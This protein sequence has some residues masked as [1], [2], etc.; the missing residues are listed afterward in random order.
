MRAPGD[1]LRRFAFP[2]AL[3]GLNVLLFAAFY[4]K[5]GDLIVDTSREATLP[6]RILLG[7]VPYRDFNYEYGPLALYY[8][9]FFYRLAGVNLLALNLAGL[10]VS[11]AVSVMVYALSRVFLNRPLSLF[12][13]AYFILNFAFQNT[14]GFNIYTYI[15][16]YT[17]A[18]SLGVLLLL[19]VFCAGHRWLQTG[20]AAWGLG[21][22]LGYGL[23]CLTKVEFI[24]AGAV[25][26][27]PL[28]AALL[29]KAWREGRLGWRLAGRWLAAFALP[30]LALLLPVGCYFA[31]RLDIPAYLRTEISG[32]LSF[33]LPFVRSRMGLLELTQN[34]KTFVPVL[35]AYFG[36]ALVFHA[37]DR[38]TARTA[39]RDDS[40]KRP[41]F[42]EAGGLLLAGML[43]WLAEE[44]VGGPNV[45][46]GM[47]V[48]LPLI[49]GGALVVAW[50][51]WRQRSLPP[52]AL[53]VAC[54]SASACVLLVRVV[55]NARP[56]GYG[57]FL[58]VPGLLL[59]LAGVFAFLPALFRRRDAGNRIYRWGFVVFLTAMTA[60]HFKYSLDLYREKN[61]PVTT[62]RGTLWLPPD[63]QQA[64]AGL[65][66]FFRDKPVGHLL[67]LPEGAMLNFL[68]D[69]PPVT[70]S[71]AFVPPLLDTPA[72]E[73]RVIRE[74]R[75]KPIDYIL[76][77]SR[78]TDEFGFSVF[79]FDYAWRL[80]RAFDADYAAVAQFGPPPFNPQRYFG[81]LAMERT[82]RRPA[83]EMAAPPPAGL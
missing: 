62:A 18:A 57:V 40:G 23:L 9:A 42:A 30:A 78:W 52:R 79:G 31:R 56:V 11:A 6:W 41:L 39:A 46:A 32:M 67:A 49:G 64:L 7:D 73:D 66:E 44:W 80:K 61:C 29:L 81:I 63:Q 50:R 8:V 75:E 21:M 76:I 3:V 33:D 36:L 54:L 59:T 17:F 65:L 38:W 14:G 35:A 47:A 10:A 82:D 24:L 15:L 2:L 5:F 27:L 12:A 51:G 43:A 34:L 20:R 13:G 48:W 55:F 37:L 60:Q 25:F 1:G 83:P 74:L 77:V 26:V 53:F 22:G 19:L 58:L 28:F 16:P 70:Y 71:Y 72:K 68:L 4:G 45:L 69:S